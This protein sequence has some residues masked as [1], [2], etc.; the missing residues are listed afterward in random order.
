MDFLMVHDPDHAL[1]RK[2]ELMTS[3]RV[4]TYA[5]EIGRPV[6]A[7]ARELVVGKAARGYV[8]RYRYLPRVAVALVLAIRHQRESR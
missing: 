3:L 2:A 7:G 4:L 1:E 6:T 5:P 8:V